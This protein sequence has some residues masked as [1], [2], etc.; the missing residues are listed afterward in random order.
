MSSLKKNWHQVKEG[1]TSTSIKQVIS[2]PPNTV[3]FCY[4]ALNEFFVGFFSEINVISVKLII[5]KGFFVILKRFELDI[6]T[7]YLD[8]LLKLSK[9]PPPPPLPWNLQN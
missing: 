4:L 5:M 9:S 6:E 8:S 3:V 2:K 7:Y 1:W